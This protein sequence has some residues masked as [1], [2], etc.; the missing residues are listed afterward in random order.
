MLEWPR[1]SSVAAAVVHQQP[2]YQT[3]ITLTK[4]LFTLHTIISFA[5]G[6]YLVTDRVPKKWISGFHYG[7]GVPKKL[8]I[9]GQKFGKFSKLNHF[10]SSNLGHSV[11][12]QE[13]T[14]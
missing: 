1:A 2:Q 4:A 9:H 3:I 12:V 6:D 8:Y 7:Y 14:K 10:L 11:S 13:F 5:K